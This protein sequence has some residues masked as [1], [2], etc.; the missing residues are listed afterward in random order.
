MR[1][2]SR[3][4]ISM[5]AAMGL[6]LVLTVLGA[7]LGLLFGVEGGTPE[8][9]E[10][11][12]PFKASPLPDGLVAR[13]FVVGEEPV[14]K[15]ETAEDRVLARGLASH[16]LDQPDWMSGRTWIDEAD[17][18]RFSESSSDYDGCH[19]VEPPVSAHSVTPELPADVVEQVT[20]SSSLT[21]DQPVQTDYVILA[22]GTVWQ[23]GPFGSGGILLLAGLFSAL[24]GT[25]V[26]AIGGA[27]VAVL[28]LVAWFIWRRLRR[29]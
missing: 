7:F 3:S 13:A 16:G 8:S 10:S 9:I 21:P 12:Q 5:L 1:P 15:V 6:V 11:S 26:G 14:V 2:S 20:C 29:H 18:P 24:A 25:V 23:R 17:L 19:R 4:C 27:V 22:D 28:I